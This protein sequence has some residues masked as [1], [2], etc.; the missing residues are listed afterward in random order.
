MS[1]RGYMQLA[2][3]G[4]PAADALAPFPN[5][6]VGSPTVQCSQGSIN[7]LVQTTNGLPSRIF[8]KGRND[9]AGCYFDNTA[10]VTFSLSA[11]NMNRKRQVLLSVAGVV[12][13]CI[14]R[15]NRVVYNTAWWSWC[16]CIHS[17]SPRS[18]RPT[19]FSVFTWKPT[20][21]SLADWKSGV[22]IHAQ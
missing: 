14:R 10:N 17:S 22:C 1:T 6:I 2:Y 12:D 9:V 7:M 21:L 11:C 3:W 18:T 8:A 4:A 13:A 5:E 19:T 16:N 20:S 15:L